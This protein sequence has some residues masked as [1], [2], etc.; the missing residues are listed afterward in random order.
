[1]EGLSDGGIQFMSIFGEFS[2]N[3]LRIEWFYTWSKYKNWNIIIDRAWDEFRYCRSFG[4]DI[5]LFSR[6]NT[7][8]SLLK[9]ESIAAPTD[10]F[11][12]IFLY[13]RLEQYE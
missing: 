10:S 12:C 6:Q 2:K 11:N 13:D 8:L 1:M 7:I 9:K 4:C 5:F 3:Y